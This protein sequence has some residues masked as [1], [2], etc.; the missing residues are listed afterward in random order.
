M[1]SATKNRSLVKTGNVTLMRM[2]IQTSSALQ[3]TSSLH[4]KWLYSHCGCWLIS[5][6]NLWKHLKSIWSPTA[7]ITIVHL[8][9]VLS[10][11]KWRSSKLW[12]SQSAYHDVERSQWY[13]DLG[14]EVSLRQMTHAKNNSDCNNCKKSTGIH[15]LVLAVLL[16]PIRQL[17]GKVIKPAD[18][19]SSNDH[20]CVFSLIIIVL[21]H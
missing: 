20:C 11:N 2:L 4:Q 3:E 7:T 21:L 6:S 16:V 14:F 10:W 1:V 15:W 18:T 5:Q 19:D 8:S 9:V 12:V 17:Y 13:L